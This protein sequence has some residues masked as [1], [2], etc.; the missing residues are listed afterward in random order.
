MTTTK[1]SCQ[2]MCITLKKILCWNINHYPLIMCVLYHCDMQ[3]N[4]GD[5]RHLTARN[6]STLDSSA[7]STQVSEYPQG[8]PE[9]SEYSYST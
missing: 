5:Q 4:L 6:I 8:V 2:K 1:Q 7:W 3:G 9:Y